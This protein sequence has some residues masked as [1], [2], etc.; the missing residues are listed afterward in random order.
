MYILISI[1]V[2]TLSDNRK[3]EKVK[4]DLGVKVVLRSGHG[5]FQGRMFFHYWVL[6]SGNNASEN[7]YKDDDGQLRLLWLM[8]SCQPNNSIRTIIRII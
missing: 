2:S 4:I 5:N 8:A 3:V 7:F 1:S 6:P